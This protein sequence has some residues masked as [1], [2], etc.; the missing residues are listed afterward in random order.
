MPVDAQAEEGDL[1]GARDAVV[2]LLD[3]LYTTA[4]VDPGRWEGGAFPELGS[5]FTGRAA[6]RAEQ[7]REGLTLGQD[8]ARIERVVPTSATLRLSILVDPQA[9]P[10]A[11]IATAAFRGDGRTTDGG[12]V[13]IVHEGRYLVRRVEGGWRII[14]YDVQGSLESVADPGPGT[15]GA[16]PEATP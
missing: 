2:D 1:E 4:F 14:G 13:E 6:A 10:Y 15:P 3:E 9:A 16:T 12:A 8:A 5:Y 7:D 11:A